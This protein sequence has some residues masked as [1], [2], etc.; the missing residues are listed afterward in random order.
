MFHIQVRARSKGTAP[1]LWRVVFK[2]YGLTIFGSGVLK[3][4]ADLSGF[5]GPL[6]IRFIVDYVADVVNVN[7]GE[8][9]EQDILRGKV[10][11]HL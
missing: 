2:V 4:V 1:S 10:S 7:R 3:L 5:V 8:A 9:D 11:E 6:V